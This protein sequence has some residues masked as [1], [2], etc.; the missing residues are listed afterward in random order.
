MKIKSVFIFLIF[1][2]LTFNVEAS[3][4]KNFH[5][6]NKIAKIQKGI[7]FLSG[8]NELFS[9]TNNFNKYWKYKFKNNDGKVVWLVLGS[10]KESNFFYM[11]KT[12]SLEIIKEISDNEEQSDKWEIYLNMPTLNGLSFL[13]AL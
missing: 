3:N 4:F 7:E 6:L 9:S 13:L 10:K 2:L 1:C 12:K 5:K 8:E 11:K